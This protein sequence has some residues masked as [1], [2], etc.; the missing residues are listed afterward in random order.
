MTHRLPVASAFVVLLTI[1][2]LCHAQGV[3]QVNL[4]WTARYGG[5]SNVIDQAKAI[6]VDEA[7][8]TYVTGGGDR[9]GPTLGGDIITVKYDD[10]G[11]ELWAARYSNPGPLADAPTALAIDSDGN[12]YVT[13]YS[14]GHPSIITSQDYVT[15]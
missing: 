15:L 7:G 14:H 12:V 13:G 9:N 4:T 2:I 6:A 5:P 1:L 10:A 8:N 11:N 3:A